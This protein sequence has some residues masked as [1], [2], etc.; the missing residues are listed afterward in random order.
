MAKRQQ[1]IEDVRE[2]VVARLTWR[3]ARRDDGQ[4][5]QAVQA[6]EELDAVFPLGEVGLLDE[7]YQFLDGSGVLA[8]ITALELPRGRARVP[9]GRP[10][11]AALSA[12]DAAG[13]RVDERLAGVAL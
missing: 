4:V 9:A 7:F 2:T 3:T 6:G 10:V 1:T 13:D 11:R 8:Q 12:Q 5:A